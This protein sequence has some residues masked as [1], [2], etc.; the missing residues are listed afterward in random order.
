MNMC[1][2]EKKFPVD[3]GDGES[4]M[5]TKEEIDEYNSRNWHK[6]LPE[7]YIVEDDPAAGQ[8]MSDYMLLGVRTVEVLTRDEYDYLVRKMLMSTL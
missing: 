2:E 3:F 8:K 1:E 5:M 6:T 4:I 7:Y